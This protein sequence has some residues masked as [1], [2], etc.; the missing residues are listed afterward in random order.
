MA[1]RIAPM[2]QE[3]LRRE[4]RP[5]IRNESHLAFIRQLSCVICGSRPVDPAHLRTGN[6]LL[7]LRAVGVAEKPSD[8][9]RVTP[10][11]RLHHDEQ[12]WIGDEIRFWSS[13]G[14]DNPWQLALAL[15]A[16]SGNVEAGEA[17]VAEHR[18]LAL[19]FGTG[20]LR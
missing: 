19:G 2:L 12:H 14:I 4:R 17:I 18:M 13:H 10:L 15:Y 20:E 1:S 11:C 5:R 6:R 9:G 8:G 16:V 7:G 3:P